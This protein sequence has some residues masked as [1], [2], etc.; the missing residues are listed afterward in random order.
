MPVYNEALNLEAV[1]E[2]WM[3]VLQPASADLRF[4][5][6]NDGSRDNSAAVLEAMQARHG[7]FLIVYN[8][9]NA[10]HG[11]SC[12]FG[13][14]EALKLGL[15]WVFQIDSDGQCDPQYFR[16]FLENAQDH[17]CLF[18]YRK[19]REDGIARKIIS[20]GCRCATIWATGVDLKDPNVPYR[21]MRRE[22]LQ[23]ALTKVPA[24]LDMQNVA[25]SLAL[26]RD[27][28]LRW[29]Y[30]PMVFRARRA[31]ENSIHLLKILRMGWN[32]LNDLKRV[33]G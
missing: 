31:G 3:R 20:V 32:L 4:L 21:M 7:A 8:R 2:E 30:V 19:V 25:L 29:K 11:R 28:A 24:E 10:G 33:G 22:A 27:P 6:I 15:E 17:D 16:H 23:N 9:Q 26:K 13:Y 12:R 18:G 14:E 1:L 5:V